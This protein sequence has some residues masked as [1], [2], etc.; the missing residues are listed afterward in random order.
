MT[1]V[2]VLLVLIV[3]QLVRTIQYLAVIANQANNNTIQ[4]GHV[5]TE[6]RKRTN[7]GR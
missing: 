3:L 2:I 1:I 5:L 6:L 4:N 7:V